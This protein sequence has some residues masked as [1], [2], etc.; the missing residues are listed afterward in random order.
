MTT[1]INVVQNDVGYDINFTL[2]DANDVVVDISGGTLLFKVQQQGEAALKFSGTMAIVSGVAGTC[3]YTVAA[4]NFDV[5]GDHYAEVQV[6]IASKVITF[7]DI[8]VRVKPEIP[9]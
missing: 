7:S 4:G 1:N 9:R 5:V 8:T 6:T 3:K 2:K